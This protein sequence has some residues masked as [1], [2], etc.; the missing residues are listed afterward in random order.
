MSSDRDPRSDLGAWLGEELR[1]A[2]VAAGYASQDQLARE[3]GF[4]R[5]VIVKA[6]TGTRPPSEDVA[7]RIEEMFP[8]LCN[9]LYAHLATIARRSNG[10][11]PGWFADWTEAERAATVIKWWEPLLV[12]GLLQTPEYARALFRAWEMARTEDELEEL[13]QARMARQAVLDRAEPPKLWAVIDETVLH[14]RVGGAKVM[15]DQVLKLSE[16]ADRPGVSIHVIPAE[17]GA[18]IGLLGAF[19]IAST[20]GDAAGI[21]Y[22]ESP[23]EGQTT[24]NPITVAKINLTFDTLRSEALPRS[25]SRDILAKVAEG[26]GRE[27]RPLA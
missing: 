27:Q 24:R 8:G 25:A 1:R 13:V 11:V 15:H 3:L 14:R 20:D 18:H 5:T 2:R 16:M 17:T 12:P 22:M 10:P 21:V 19:A 26:N 23:D 7:A 9:G 6:E 4:D